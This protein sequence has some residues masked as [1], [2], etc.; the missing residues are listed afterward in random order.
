[1]EEVLR[2]P[3]FIA[4]AFLTL[5][6]ALTAGD[7]IAPPANEPAP[8]PQLNAQLTRLVSGMRLSG[9]VESRKFA[10]T[11]V[12]VTDPRHPRYAGVNDNV[13]MYAASLPKIAVL[14]AGFEQIRAGLLNYTPGI[15]SMFERIARRSSN[16]DASKAIQMVGFENIARVLTSAKY[17]LYDPQLNGGLWLGKAYGGPNGFWKRDPI[18]NLSH[19]ATAF[20]AARFFVLLAQRKLVDPQSSDEIKDILG[21]PEIRHKFVKGLSGIPDVAIY[22]KSGTWDRW[23]ADAALVEHAGRKYVA[24]GL[25]EDRRGGEILEHL[26]RGL[27]SIICGQAVV[28]HAPSGK[29]LDEPLDLPGDS[30]VLTR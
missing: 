9:M 1:M 17:K 13:M 23:H 30:H 19:G 4:A 10:V 8:D 25:V 18:H 24:V 11:L 27:D 14:V 6:C 12:D 16:A 7:A 2:P 29:A 21:Q 5:A 26:I 3:V 15:R 28:A 20:Q 22:R